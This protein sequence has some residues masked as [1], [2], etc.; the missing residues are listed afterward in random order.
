MKRQCDKCQCHKI[1]DAFPPA[2]LNQTGA[3]VK[4]YC[5]ACCK[6]FVTLRC[7]KCTSNKLV[8]DF[9]APMITMP[10]ACV[11]CKTCQEQAME[12]AQRNRDGW[13]TCRSCR[14][15][16]P[17]GS[18]P[19]NAG[20]QQE[21]QQRRCLNCTENTR[22]QQGEHTCRNPACGKKWKE[23]QSQDHRHRLCPQCRRATSKKA[24]GSH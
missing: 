2:Q 13:I 24:L 15:I 9:V 7:S 19:V 14:V 4:T 5:L 12:K 17:R 10:P 1:E 18:I 22:R 20:K 11:A 3:D 16:F 6:T 21:Q 8:Q 23:Q